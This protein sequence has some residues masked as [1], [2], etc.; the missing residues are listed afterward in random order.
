MRG[1]PLSPGSMLRGGLR[2][3]ASSR[4]GRSAPEQRFGRGSGRVDTRF[5][6]DPPGTA[7]AA[8]RFRFGSGRGPCSGWNFT[9]IRMT[10]RASGC[11]CG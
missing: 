5:P 10:R 11:S 8:D 1:S 2:L 4:M 3:A 6:H 7:H 9:E